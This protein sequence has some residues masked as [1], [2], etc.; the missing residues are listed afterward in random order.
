MTD[1][2]WG[3]GRWEVNEEA[4]RPAQSKS[5]GISVRSEVSAEVA[6]SSPD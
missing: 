2:G 5:T 4:G 6:N 3:C 1:D